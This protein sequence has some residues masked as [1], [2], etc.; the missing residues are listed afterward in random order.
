[1]S[2]QTAGSTHV[3]EKQARAVA[4]EAREDGLDRAVVRQGAV[5]RPVP[6]RPHP[7]APA[8]RT[9]DAAPRDR[10]VPR[11]A[12]RRTATPSTARVIE[13]EARIPDEY[14]KGFAELGCF[15]MKIPTEYGGLGL[16]H[17]ALRPGA[18]AGRL[19]PPE[20]RRAAVG[21]P[22]DRRARAGEAVRHRRA[23]AR[24][25]CRA[26]RRGAVTAFLLTEPDVGSDPARLAHDR[27][28]DRRRRR[29][30]SSTA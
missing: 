14:V 8:A 13:R 21:A 26:A 19:G 23:E 12:A 1:M 10:G 18:D 6:A 25:S 16:S 29:R 7:P 22:V 24:R 30:T 5:P 2:Q 20:P 9:A 11:P 15:G 28:A 27:D 4:E 3:D 17:V